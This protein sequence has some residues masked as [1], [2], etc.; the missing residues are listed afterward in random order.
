MGKI[1]DRGGELEVAF[2]WNGVRNMSKIVER[3][4]VK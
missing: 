1:W 3:K 2:D 4:K